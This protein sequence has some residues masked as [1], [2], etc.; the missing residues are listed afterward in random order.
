MS[1]YLSLFQQSGLNP[2][3]HLVWIA[4][5]K[6]HEFLFAH[7]RGLLALTKTFITEIRT[8]ILVLIEIILVMML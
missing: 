5:V 2:I 3:N 4:D 6:A 8:E 7:S 1:S